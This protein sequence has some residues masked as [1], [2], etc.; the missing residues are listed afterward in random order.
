MPKT[1]RTTF[2]LGVLYGAL[3]IFLVPILLAKVNKVYGL[4]F[5]TIPELQLVGMA[6]IL[7]G[8]GVLGV[9]LTE[10]FLHDQTPLP[11]VEPTRLVTTGAY[12]YSRNPMFVSAAMIWL[13][14]AMLTGSLLNYAFFIVG[15]ALNHYHVVFE[16]EKYLKKTFGDKYTH[17][18]K[19][20]A[21]YIPRLV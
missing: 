5:L 6:L 14:Q 20:T 7:I 12:K 21:R 18:M 8:G 16:E 10:Y 15:C 13:G 2:L 11:T 1:S 17:Y 4:P 19:K 9:A 3:G